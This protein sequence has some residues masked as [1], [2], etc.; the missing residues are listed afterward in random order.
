VGLTTQSTGVYAFLEEMKADSGPN[1]DAVIA[2]AGNPNTGK[3]TVFN[4]LTGLNQHTGNWPGKTVVLAKGNYQHHSKRITLVDLP[5]TYSLLA[6]SADE[7][8]ARDFICFGE[9]DATVVVAD[10]SCLERNLNLVLQVLEITS[11][12]VLCVN[13]IDEA[14]RKKIEIDISRLEG[15]LGIPVIPTAAGDKVGLNQLKDAIHQVAFGKKH[16]APEQLVY[17]ESIEAAIAVIQPEVEGLLQ[18]KFNSRWVALRLLDGDTSIITEILHYLQR[19]EQNPQQPIQNVR[20][21]VAL[22]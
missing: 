11:R 19:M 2:L 17:H 9:P 7:Q 15:L 5:G 4:G 13:L 22:E 20:G 18:G 16:V 21:W 3:S 1:A 14:G 8:V 12:T 10:A 6:N